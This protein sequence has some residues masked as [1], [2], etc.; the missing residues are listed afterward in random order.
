[1]I[2]EIGNV[3]TVED[4]KFYTDFHVLLVSVLNS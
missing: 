3:N 4:I 1:M 2:C